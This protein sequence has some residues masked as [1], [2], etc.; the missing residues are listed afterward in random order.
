[1]NRVDNLVTKDLKIFKDILSKY[2]I[3]DLFLSKYLISDLFL[4]KYLKSDFF[5]KAELP[6]ELR[7]QYLT[8]SKSV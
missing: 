4:S 7:N 2:L 1:M 3:S 6:I 5:L 8:K